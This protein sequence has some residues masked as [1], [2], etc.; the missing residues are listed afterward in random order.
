GHWR[1]LSR[2]GAARGRQPANQGHG[3]PM[4]G[5]ANGM[6]RI[7]PYLGG[8]L[9]VLGSATAAFLLLDEAPRAGKPAEPAA[10]RAPPQPPVDRPSAPAMANRPA[11]NR[12]APPAASSADLKTARFI[13]EHR[14]D[15][16]RAPLGS[17]VSASLTQAD[18][19]KELDDL[20]QGVLKFEAIN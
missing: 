18:V 13:I 2:T 9:L 11:Q 10:T 3:G 16:L 19:L 6:R 5:Q 14:D 8:L 17:G 1:R 7:G 15:M 12:L 4:S 20:R